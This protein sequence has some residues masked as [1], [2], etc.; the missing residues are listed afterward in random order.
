VALLT[1]F[2][3]VVPVPQASGQQTAAQTPAAKP[4]AP[5]Q[6]PASTTQAPAPKASAP[7][8]AAPAATAGEPDGGW[9][10]AYTTPTGGRVLL[11]QPQIASWDG[12]KHMVAYSAVSYEMKGAQ[13][14]ALG[15]IHVESTTTV[16]LEERLV[17]FSPIQVK[18]A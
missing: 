5:V 16:S 10:R 17:K 6:K 2:G 3:L 18:E 12:Q 7:R 15:T 8:G 9:P 14:P 1:A 4:A 13:K 11:Y